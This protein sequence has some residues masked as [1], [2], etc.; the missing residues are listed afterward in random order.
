MSR[1]G[2]IRRRKPGSSSCVPPARRSS[3]SSPSSRRS[4]TASA[5][6][7]RSG[8]NR[9]GGPMAAVS[10]KEV[11]SVAAVRLIVVVLLV[12]G[13]LLVVLCRRCLSLGLGLR[14]GGS[15]GRLALARVQRGLL[16]LR[17]VVGRLDL[18]RGTGRQRRER[19]RFYGSGQLAG[20]IRVPGA[21]GGGHRADGE[22][23]DGSRD[24]EYGSNHAQILPAFEVPSR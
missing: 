9:N 24:D 1:W 18:E 5:S 4:G 11:S 22:Q 21:R 16:S 6:S 20:A 8:E 3:V 12:V 19:P 7:H 13:V 15:S 2:P 14:L 23:Y 10:G 17:F